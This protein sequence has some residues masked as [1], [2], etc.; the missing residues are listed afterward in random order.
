MHGGML[1]I[2]KFTQTN[3]Q[4]VVGPN[5]HRNFPQLLDQHEEVV[6]NKE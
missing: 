3:G 4:L 6:V 2:Q 1:A 5:A